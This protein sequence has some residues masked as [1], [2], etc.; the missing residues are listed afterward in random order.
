MHIKY[1]SWVRDQ[2]G[3]ESENITL[4]NE[5][6]SVNDL[7]KYLK[8]K[9]E[10]HNKALGDISVIRCAVNMEVVNLDFSI[11]DNDEIALFPPMTGG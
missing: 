4:S 8:N 7:L 3:V 10:K 1:F 5:I 2:I 11:D 9:S 6:T